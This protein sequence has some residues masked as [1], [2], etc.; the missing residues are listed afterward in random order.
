[1]PPATVNMCDGMT[2]SSSPTCPLQQSTC[3][4]AWQV[5][6]VIHAPCNSQHMWRHD[7]EFE[8]SMPPATVNMCDGMTGSSSPTCPLQQSTYVTAWQVVRALH[9]PCNSQHIWQ[10]DR[11]FESSMP[12]ATVNMCDGMTGSS[13]P[14]CPL[15]QSTCVTAWQGVPVLHAPYNSQHVW[16]HDR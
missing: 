8:S 3:V 14:T 1:M 16:R 2:G 6:R 4:T 7:R 9:A 15:Q 5:V 10:H 13:S 11:E 12:P